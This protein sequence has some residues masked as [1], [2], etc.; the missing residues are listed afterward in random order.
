MSL[1]IDFGFLVSVRVLPG[2]NCASSE[3]GIKEPIGSNSVALYRALRSPYLI[4]VTDKSSCRCSRRRCHGILGK[5]PFLTRP[6]WHHCVTI[7][8]QTLNY[9]SR[10]RHFLSKIASFEKFGP[11]PL[12][13]LFNVFLLLSRVLTRKRDIDCKLELIVM[14]QF[15]TSRSTNGWYSVEGV[16]LWLRAIGVSALWITN[17]VDQPTRLAVV[18]WDS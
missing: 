13:C 18:R 7:A 8:Q 6:M 11:F 5:M 10:G 2:I 4:P 14:G 15:V 17:A 16:L 3:S 12:Y 1:H 9:S